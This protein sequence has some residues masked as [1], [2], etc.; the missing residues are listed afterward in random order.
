MLSDAS[1]KHARAR[2]RREMPWKYNGRQFSGDQWNLDVD[3]ARVTI[4]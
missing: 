2:A 4:A 3:H 1:R